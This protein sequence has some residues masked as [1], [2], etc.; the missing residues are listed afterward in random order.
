MNGSPPPP[1]YPYQTPPRS[2]GGGG[3]FLKGCLVVVVIVMLLGMAVGGLGWYLWNSVQPFLAHEPA[4]HTFQG[5][6]AAEDATAQKLA[7]F[8][9]AVAAGQRATVSL[10]GDD[11]NGLMAHDPQLSKYRDHLYLSVV[12]GQIVAETTFPVIDGGGLRP[13]QRWFFNARVVLDASYSTGDFAL[14]LARF[15]TLDGRQPSPLLLSM[16]KS[17]I[18]NVSLGF[19]RD[20]HEHPE[21]YGSLQQLTAQIRTIIIQNNQI[22]ATSVDHPKPEAAPVAVP[23]EPR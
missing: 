7:A 2:T 9:Q 16:A 21:Q 14:L 11:L 4:I 22:V 3:C 1:T 6:A 15:E 5:G 20:F 23:P 13:D 19:N 17:Y 12:N 10:T 18:S 8:S